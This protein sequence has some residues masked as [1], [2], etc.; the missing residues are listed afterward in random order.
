MHA[1]LMLIANTTANQDVEPVTCQCARRRT[2]P[3]Q[4]GNLESSNGAREELR[5]SFPTHL[6]RLKRRKADTFVP[7]EVM[8]TEEAGDHMK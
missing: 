2:G 1:F 7:S 5:L 6:Q 3:G 8:E 4:A